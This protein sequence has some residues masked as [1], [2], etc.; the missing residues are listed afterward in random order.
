[1]QRLFETTT[2]SRWECD[3]CGEK[4]N[5][6]AGRSEQTSG[7]KPLHIRKAHAVEADTERPLQHYLKQDW[8]RSTLHL[9]CADCSYAKLHDPAV[10]DSL[11]R[12]VSEDILAAPDYLVLGI[13]SSAGADG[14]FHV[15]GGN[16]VRVPLWL[17]LNRYKHPEFQGTKDDLRYKL[18]ATVYHHGSSASGHYWGVFTGPKG[19]RK[20]D[21]KNVDKASVSELCWAPVARPLMYSERKIK[22]TGKIVSEYVGTQP[23]VLFYKRFGVGSKED[24]KKIDERPKADQDK[25][26][27]PQSAPSTKSTTPNGGKRSSAKR[28]SLGGSAGASSISDELHA[29]KTPSK[30]RKVGRASARS[31]RGS[32]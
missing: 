14:L 1:M 12:N 2:K 24:V 15:K 5:T 22:T 4:G 30:K 28:K 10:E 18:C 9:T 7:I 31:L 6:R 25:H 13:A 8:F 11:D 29:E 21:N 19:T 26:S 27:K 17:D 20:I 16:R 23:Y 3:Q 32:K